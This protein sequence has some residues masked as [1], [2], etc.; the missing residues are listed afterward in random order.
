MVGFRFQGSGFRF[1]GLAFRHTHGDV[2]LVQEALK[3]D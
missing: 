2:G 3:K 1:Q